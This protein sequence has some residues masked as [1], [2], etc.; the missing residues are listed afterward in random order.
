MKGGLNLG[1]YWVLFFLLSIR[2]VCLLRKYELGL[3]YSVVGISS[4]FFFFFFLMQCSV[5]RFFFFFFLWLIRAGFGFCSPFFISS[6]LSGTK[7]KFSCLGARLLFGC[8]D[9]KLCLR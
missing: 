1:F 9:M 2:S 6:V 7:R 8:E 3:L 5:E 4:V